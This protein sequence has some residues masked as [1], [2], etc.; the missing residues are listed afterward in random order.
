MSDTGDF[1]LFGK[2]ILPQAEEAPSNNQLPLQPILI[3]EPNNSEGPNSQPNQSLI[4]IGQL[5]PSFVTE[6]QNQQPVAQNKYDEM[7]LTME[8]LFQS[9]PADSSQGIVPKSVPQPDTS[10]L[11]QEC[12]DIYTSEILLPS[13]SSQQLPHLEHAAQSTVLKDNYM[14]RFSETVTSIASDGMLTNVSEPTNPVLTYEAHPAP[15]PTDSEFEYDTLS[16]DSSELLSHTKS[17][18]R[19]TSVSRTNKERVA[20]ELKDEKYWSLRRK[21]NLAAKRSRDNRRLKDMKI[22]MKAEALDKQNARLQAELHKL[23]ELY[24]NALK[25]LERY[26]AQPQV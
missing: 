25:R 14:L 5:E 7:E 24:K 18:S 13:W 19:V 9:Y 3:Q 22:S 2:W 15:T 23:M 4:L 26:E 21:N 10:Q 17:S 16:G 12:N 11:T 8:Y 20:A 1:S 6:N